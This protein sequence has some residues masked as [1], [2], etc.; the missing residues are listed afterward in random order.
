MA[1]SSLWRASWDRVLL[2]FFVDMVEV[3]D[4]KDLG[5][6][7]G[8]AT[9]MPEGS[10]QAM[11]GIQARYGC[12]SKFSVHPFCLVQPVHQCFSGAFW[13]RFLKLLL[14]KK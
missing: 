11:F 4:Q 6:R 13:S 10:G 8:N 7:M 9:G 1:I 12:G 2:C 14:I 5:S 3:A